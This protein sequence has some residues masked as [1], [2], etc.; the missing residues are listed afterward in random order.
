MLL[1]PWRD[2]RRLKEEGQSWEDSLS[3]FLS[4]AS[5]EEHRIINNI[6]YFHQACDTPNIRHSPN[7][8]N[9][10][11]DGNLPS[12]NQTTNAYDAVTSVTERDFLELRNQKK[13]GREELHALEAMLIAK[14]HGIFPE[15]P[16]DWETSSQQAGIGHAC[17]DDVQKLSAWKGEMDAKVASQNCE[18]RLLSEESHSVRDRGE[19]SLI[20]DVP[21]AP[22]VQSI[23]VKR[24]PDEMPALDPTE[25]NDEQ[26][27]CFNIVSTHLERT[28]AKEKVAPLRLLIY[29]EG[30]TGKSRVIQ[31]ITERFRQA[32]KMG[33]LLKAAYTGVAASLIGGKTTHSIAL[34]SR[35]DGRPVSDETRSKLQEFWSPYRYLIIDEISMISKI[36]LAI[37]ERN[38]GIGKAGLISESD[39]DSFGGLSVIICGDFHQFPPV[40]SPMRDALFFP[41]ISSDSMLSQIGRNLYE[42]FTTV[43]TLTQQMRV[44][45]PVWREFLSSLRNGEVRP[46]H[47]T[48]LK[49]LVL[50]HASCPT[51]NFSDAHWT[52]SVL[53]TPRHAVR[54]QWNDLA[55]TKHSIVT[56]HKIFVCN[57]DDSIKGKPLTTEERYSFEQRT[58]GPSRQREARVDLPNQLRLAVGMPVLLT[59]NVETD[60][61]ITNGANGHIV[62]IVLHQDEEP[63]DAE[64]SVVHLQRLPLYILVKLR[65][66]RAGK[67]TGLEECVIPIQPA[68]QTMRIKYVVEGNVEVT[69]NVVRKQFPI[70]PAYAFTDYR[71]QGQTIPCA[72]A[73]IAPPATGGLSLFNIYV[74]L[75]RVPSRDRIRLLR[76]FREEMLLNKSFPPE[77]KE[78]DDRIS[79][80]YRNTSSL[81]NEA[82]L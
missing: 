56:G 67:L 16:D 24:K 47:I 54:N 51:T 17:V 43:V 29:G 25:L 73:D 8:V 50:G 57:A 44:S 71:A 41:S 72:I 66:T 49:S 52:S 64:H 42:Q 58:T 55:T 75:S 45:D 39:D 36:F 37:I 7:F 34:V 46:E 3:E 68:S 63:H 9:E 31:S 40:A 79:Q 2:V 18:A 23:P 33:W 20:S 28:L 27:M 1:K 80:L 69:R 32:G 77:L 82:A 26:R 13:F 59:Q 19:T 61:D 53:I 78:E 14:G 4:S 81:Y 70:T 10:H 74:T 62:G 76:Y 60:L 11:D 12:E 22:S 38:I 6:Q 5:L 15:Q 35:T 48:M 30:G 21:L 65:H